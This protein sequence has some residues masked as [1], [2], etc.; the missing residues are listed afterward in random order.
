MN[1]ISN[2]KIISNFNSSFNRILNHKII[3]V[4]TQWEHGDNAKLQRVI[5]NNFCHLLFCFQKKKTNPNWSKQDFLRLSIFF[6]H[7]F[8]CI[9]VKNSNS[10]TKFWTFQT[11]TCIV[12]YLVI[13]IFR[14][15]L[16]N[17]GFFF[18]QKTSKF[19]WILFDLG[20]IS[21]SV[22]H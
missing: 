19:T 15:K 11:R 8:L 17:F 1:R 21:I 5:F 12:Y 14:S 7:A 4:L 2:H 9:L 20:T 18:Q 13:L 10:K 22:S 3:I 16:F 6:V